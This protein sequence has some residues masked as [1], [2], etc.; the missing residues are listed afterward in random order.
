MIARNVE[1]MHYVPISLLKHFTDDEAYLHVYHIDERRWFKSR[2]DAFGFENYMYSQDVEVWL[3]RE[4]ESLAG[5]AFKKVRSGDTNLSEDERLKIARFIS[6]QVFRTRLAKE[7]ISN[8]D[9]EYL[10]KMFQDEKFASETLE[11]ICE[12]PLSLEE[13]EEVKRRSLLSKAE[14]I[15]ELR[16]IRLEGMKDDYPF[17]LNQKMIGDKNPTHIVNQEVDFFMR[18]VWKVIK[19]EK[20]SFILSDNPVTITPISGLGM[21]SPQFE[22]VLPISRKVTIHIGR[23]KNSSGKG[24]ELVSSD[25]AVKQINL[26]TLGNAYQY[27]ISHREDSWIRKITKRK[28]ITYLPL[29]FSNEIIDIQYG[30]PPCPNCGT[31]LTAEL[32]DT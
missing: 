15:E 4:V 24:V 26:R 27:V 19:A 10:C 5:V 9:P 25:K 28:P 16:S 17:I 22:C 12:R 1:H 30:R 29:R 23:N 7:R 3:D 11:T 8:D 31:E 21:D 2:P 6:W 14:L 18:L 20:E 32:W 13:K